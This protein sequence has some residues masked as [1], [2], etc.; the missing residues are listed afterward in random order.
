MGRKAWRALRE[1]ED[2][3]SGIRQAA[4]ELYANFSTHILNI[5][6]LKTAFFTHQNVGQEL[7][8]LV[9]SHDY[10]V[11]HRQTLVGL[12]A[13]V[14]DESMDFLQFKFV[15]KIHFCLS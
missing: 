3:T 8:D 14:K 1:Y 6:T 10:R 2:L 9:F 13:Q 5:F 4:L 11:F 7:A 15:F 12:A